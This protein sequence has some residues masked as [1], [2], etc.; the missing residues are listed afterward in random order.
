MFLAHKSPHIKLNSPWAFCWLGK[1]KRYQILRVTKLGPACAHYITQ[2][3]FIKFV[4][5]L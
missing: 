4:S 3:S 1:E 5:W 2:I